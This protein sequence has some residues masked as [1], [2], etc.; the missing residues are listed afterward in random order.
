MR[1]EEPG[2]GASEGWESKHREAVATLRAGALTAGLIIALSITTTARAQ[3][4]IARAQAHLIPQLS[5]NGLTLGSPILVRLFKLESELELWVLDNGRYRLFRTYPI[6]MYSGNLGPKLRQGDR[7]SP[8]GFYRV[9]AAQMNP[10]SRYHLAFNLGYPNRYDRIHHRTGGQLMI[11]GDC[12]SRG[13]YAMTDGVIEQ[14]YTLA[15]AAL[16]NGQEAFQVHAFP[17]RLS[18]ERLHR[19]RDTPWHSFWSNLK[20]GYDYFEKHRRAPTIRVR[21]RRYRIDP[22]VSRQQTA[23]LDVQSMR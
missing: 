19:Y 18:A 2:I 1:D 11:H 9:R 7:Q 23:Q 12:V 4:A 6:C 15:A 16:A 22:P 3:D 5:A 14:I 17:F 13:C 20:E 8:E 10:N 21:E